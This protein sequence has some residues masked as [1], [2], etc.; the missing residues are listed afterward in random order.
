LFGRFGR[1]L[2]SASS[3]TGKMVEADRP[4]FQGFPMLSR[5]QNLQE[6]GVQSL[7]Y[8]VPSKS[9]DFWKA[10]EWSITSIDPSNE[11][12][13]AKK[14]QATGTRIIFR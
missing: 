14:P 7:Y 3:G 6:Q 11:V 9:Q 12:E 2:L 8:G 1:G 5:W 4:L 13:G 10:K